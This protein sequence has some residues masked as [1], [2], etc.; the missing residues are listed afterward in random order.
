MGEV[1]G[2][3]I[4]PPP[5]G[6]EKP[7]AEQPKTE[8]PSWLPEKFKTEADLVKSYTELER[9]LSQMTVKPKEAPL[10]V[11][12]EKKD[13]GIPGVDPTKS[14]ITEEITKTAEAAVKKAGLNM[15]ELQKEYD[16]NG[17]LTPETKAKLAEAGIGEAEIEV[18][19]N[20]LKANG[21]AFIADA[22]KDIKGGREALN[23]A[24]NWA[25]QELARGT[26]SQAEADA[27]N[28]TME[29]GNLH[30][31]ALAAEGLVSKYRRAQGPVLVDGHAPSERAIGYES[32]AQQLAD[33]KDPR[34][35]NDPAFRDQVL[36]KSIN[37]KF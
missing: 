34:Y 9:K 21:D 17:D 14:V 7:V 10:Q 6:P 8:R 25:A 23:E 19:K 13:S 4:N 15:V 29:S 3:V 36:K 16:T 24:V 33:M 27:F 1:V 22:T 2:T 5:S 37:S 35:K 31:A 11:E 20:G 26:M 28:K 18:Y 12:P 30:Q 32:R